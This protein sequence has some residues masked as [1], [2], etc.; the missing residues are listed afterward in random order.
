MI[1]YEIYKNNNLNIFKIKKHSLY[2]FI[3]ILKLYSTINSKKFEFSKRLVVF[4]KS[5]LL[6]LIQSNLIKIQVILI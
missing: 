4:I 5:M 1:K 6:V 3:Q 2:Q